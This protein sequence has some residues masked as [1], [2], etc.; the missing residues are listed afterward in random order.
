MLSAEQTNCGFV[1]AFHKPCPKNQRQ[2]RASPLAAEW[3]ASKVKELKTLN[4][5]GTWEIVAIL[6][7][8][9][10]LP[11]TWTY[12]VRVKT[13]DQGLECQLKS[14]WCTRGDLQQQWE[15]NTTYSPTST[16]R[17]AA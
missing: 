16:G 5:M 14:R 17:M 6:H 1:S 7:N 9:T 13:D 11:G 12:R 4:D 15:Y 8:C 2:T 3:I 10:P